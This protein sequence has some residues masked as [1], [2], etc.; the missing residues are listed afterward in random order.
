MF[1]RAYRALAH[2]FPV[3]EKGPP[4]VILLGTDGV[5]LW[6]RG[7]RKLYVRFW[8]GAAVEFRVKLGKVLKEAKVSH[9]VGPE[10]DLEHKGNKVEPP[11]VGAKKADP[12]AAERPL[13]D[14][15]MVARM[16]RHP[17]VRRCLLCKELVD[18]LAGADDEYTVKA[19]EAVEEHIKE[20]PEPDNVAC[21]Y[22]GC[23]HHEDVSRA[24]ALKMV[25]LGRGDEPW[26]DVRNVQVSN[27]ALRV[28]EQDAPEGWDFK[29]QDVMQRHFRE[30]VQS[31][32]D[33]YVRL[34]PKKT[35]LHVWI[36]PAYKSRREDVEDVPTL[37][38]IRET[39]EKQTPAI[40]AWCLKKFNDLKALA[41]MD[42]ELEGGEKA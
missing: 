15:M 42:M 10:Y 14:A 12:E 28:R 27:I 25:E 1:E 23:V 35:T 13:S 16:S 9:E 26:R 36:S 18:A 21:G 39:F 8:R 4:G 20:V 11:V 34:G 6:A 22:A 32:G 29:R 2:K 31:A 3:V 7:R 40:R 19:A 17:H 38:D 37:E 24:L 33:I 5:V 30:L 41:Q